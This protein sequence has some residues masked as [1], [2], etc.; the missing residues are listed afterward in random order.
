MRLARRGVQAQKCRTVISWLVVQKGA[1]RVS[2]LA[3]DRRW[4]IM[5]STSV[6]CGPDAP[7]RYE[8]MTESGGITEMAESGWFENTPWQVYVVGQVLP[9]L[10]SVC[11]S[12]PRAEV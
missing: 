9:L 12:E 4:G 1:V 2:S 10:P 7:R 11:R 3:G 6:G 8:C 5:K